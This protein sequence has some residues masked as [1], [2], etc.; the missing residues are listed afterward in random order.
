MVHTDPVLRAP[1]P[2]LVRRRPSASGWWI[3]L[4]LGICGCGQAPD[5]PPTHDVILVS[6]DTLRGDRA[7]TSLNRSGE[8]RTTMPTLEQWAQ[9]GLRFE[10]AYSSAPQTAASHMSIFSG[11]APLVHGVGNAQ[12]DSKTVTALHPDWPTLAEALSEQGFATAGIAN[13]GQLLPEMGFD[14]GFDVYVSALTEPAA[15]LRHVESVLEVTPT[16]QPLFLF[17]HTYLPHAPYLPQPAR[18]E[19]FTDPGYRGPFRQRYEGLL[20]L[21]LAE[22]HRLSGQ[23]LEIDRD[24]NKRDLRFLS[25]LYDANLARADSALSRLA[26]VVENSGRDRDQLWCVT[27]DHG[28]A[29]GEH[30]ELGHKRRLDGELLHVPLVMRS[31]GFSY[32]IDA[33]TLSDPFGL[34]CLASEL[35]FGLGLEV[36]AEWNVAEGPGALS[37]IGFVQDWQQS[38]TLDRRRYFVAGGRDG[39]RSW[40]FDLESDPLEQNPLEPTYDDSARFEYLDQVMLRAAQDT[41]DRR[42]VRRAIEL[43]SR[44]QAELEALGYAED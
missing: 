6:L 5:R 2:G 4:V 27:S 26:K 21:D 17:F 1:R 32:S 30:G 14:R 44:T 40:V 38:L 37:Q 13:G 7:G 35:L 23:F 9:E 18:F 24:P 34:D 3:P 10:R 42:P 12:P 15:Q 29:F 25:D 36:P 33:G 22:A 43:D 19:A 41:R 16:D 20:G 8:R 39:R 31:V 11:L 28:E